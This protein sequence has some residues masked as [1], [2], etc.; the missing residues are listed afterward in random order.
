MQPR[1]H[2]ADPQASPYHVTRN[3]IF[4]VGTIGTGILNLGNLLNLPVITLEKYFDSGSPT[5]S[6]DLVRTEDEAWLVGS[7]RSGF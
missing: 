5:A 2:N 3:Q 7:T 1:Q 4:P 6:K